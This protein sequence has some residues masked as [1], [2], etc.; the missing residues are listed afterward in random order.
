MDPGQR[1][2]HAESLHMS[3][4]LGMRLR[5]GRDLNPHPR[6]RTAPADPRVSWLPAALRKGVRLRLRLDHHD[7][8]GRGCWQLVGLGAE[9]EGGGWGLNSQVPEGLMSTL[10]ASSEMQTPALATQ[11]MVGPPVKKRG[12]PPIR[13]L[14]FQSHYMEP[15][16][17]LK[18]PKKRGRKPGFKL[19]P[20]IV[21]SPLA[22]SPPSST[23]EPEMGS[24]PQ[25]AAIVPKSATSQVLTA[26]TP[27]PDDFLCDPLVDSKRYSVDPSDSAFNVTT[28][29]YA[30]KN[31]YSYR[32]SSCSLPGGLCRQM[33]SPGRF[34]DTNRNAY[35]PDSGECKRPA[36][37]DP[38][39]WGVEEVVS[40]IKDADPQALGPHTD[41]FRKHEIDGDA[42]LLL[43]SEMMMKYLGLKLGPALKLSYHI[44]KLKQS[45]P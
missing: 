28:S 19:K 5:G 45:W 27:V 34:H 3:R 13:K 25:D 43:K 29:Q 21:M 17:P 6:L 7:G 36:G 32:G 23:P 12:R 9:S 14:E 41:A 38:S 39:S 16:L 26:E 2:T 24:L 11:F 44:D 33:S 8:R 42:L 15:M 31:P 20:R 37:K 22:N 35:S 1:V 40:F 4:L 10:S 30:S 18:V